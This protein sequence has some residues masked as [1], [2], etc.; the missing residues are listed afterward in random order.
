MAYTSGS[1]PAWDA[2][3][4]WVNPSERTHRCLRHELHDERVQRSARVETVARRCKSLLL[5]A[6]HRTVSD[7]T[8]K[9]VI[10][11]P[12]NPRWFQSDR[13]C[14]LMNLRVTASCMES[15]CMASS[16]ASSK[17]SSFDHY[18]FCWSKLFPY[19]SPAF[20]AT[21][22]L[23]LDLHGIACMS[24]LCSATCLTNRA[25]HATAADQ[26]QPLCCCLVPL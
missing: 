17:A 7:S 13:H 19:R 8:I 18:C 22:T 21:S 1:M 16:S 3:A 24:N 5:L 23:S 14:Q 10:T 4:A 26:L 11:P 12:L 6:H 15:S 9:A 2:R 25:M 20:L